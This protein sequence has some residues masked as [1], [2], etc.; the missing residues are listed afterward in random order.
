MIDKANRIRKMKANT[1]HVVLERWRLILVQ[2]IYDNDRQ[3]M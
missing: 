2:I 1:K 3:S